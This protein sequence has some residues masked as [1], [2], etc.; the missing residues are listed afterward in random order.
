MILMRRW[1][2]LSLIFFALLI[3]LCLNLGYRSWPLTQG[4][5]YQI[6][7]SPFRG[8]FH[9]SEHKSGWRLFIREAYWTPFRTLELKDLKLKTPQGGRLH[10]V[11][12]SVD[13]EFRSLLKGRLIT[14]WTIKEIRMD[15]GSWGIRKPLAQEILSAGPVVTDGVIVLQSEWGRLTLQSLLLRGPLL[16]LHAEGWLTESLLAHLDLDGDLDRRFLEEIKL[17]KPSKGPPE[18][19]EPFRI[20]LHGM[21]ARPK[22]SFVSNFFSISLNTVREK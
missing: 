4:A 22:M 20:R 6:A 9:R 1:V 2:W 5:V 8:A 15:P 16:R 12:V 10:L 11:G 7:G 19:W 13:P 18:A 3:T 21:L 14:R 17:M